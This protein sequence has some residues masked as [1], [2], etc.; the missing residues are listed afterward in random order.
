LA[1][2]LSTAEQPIRLWDS[3]SGAEIRRFG[4]DSSFDSVTFS[5]DGKTL[6]AAGDEETLSVWDAATGKK[7]PPLKGKQR[8]ERGPLPPANA[9]AVSSDGRWLAARIGFGAL[10]KSG[11]DAKIHLWDL[12][13]GRNR[14]LR[15]Q[16]D[17]LS[18]PTFSADSKTLAALEE[19]FDPRFHH[20]VLRL[21]EVESALPRRLKLKGVGDVSAFALSPGGEVVATAESRRI[22]LW[23]IAGGTE[24]RHFDGHRGDINALAFSPDGRT[25]VSGNADTTALLWDVSDLVNRGKRRLVDL[26]PPQLDALWGDLEG[27][28]AARAGESIWKLI[29]G[30]QTV[31]FLKEHLHPVSA[32]DA[33]LVAGLIADLDGSDFAVRQRATRQLEKLG[34]RAVPA[35]RQARA[36]HASL[37][38]RRRIE[39]ILE[40]QPVMDV[41][42]LRAIEVLEH[43]GDREARQVLQTLADGMPGV[44]LTREAKASLRR[45]EKRPSRP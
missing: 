14:P 19:C 16:P 9:L 23:E 11:G 38:M 10:G 6:I 29:A 4:G 7:L 2:L 35:L 42:L 12:A 34:E 28:D 26:S 36:N 5:A 30:R 3:Q 27:E 8:E 39:S 21:W 18:A 20:N 17:I 41:R 37:E 1:V 25:L 32:P 31:A 15:R 44:R 40:R 43:I 22:R 13:T 33:R 24:L 45:L